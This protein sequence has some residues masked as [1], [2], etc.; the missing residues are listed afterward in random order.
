MSFGLENPPVLISKELT[1]DL[2]L[3]LL[4]LGC[5]SR[6]LSK[7]GGA[8]LSVHKEQEGAQGVSCPGWSS[9]LGEQTIL[10]GV[11][12]SGCEKRIAHELSS[13]WWKSMLPRVVSAWKLGAREPSRR[14]GI[15]ETRTNRELQDC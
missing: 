14:E 13:H 7:L 12:S 5:K 2:D 3:A 1:N 15:F 9:E 8:D 4:E 6:D 10:T 11:K